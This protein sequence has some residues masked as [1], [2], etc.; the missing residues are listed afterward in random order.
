MWSVYLILPL[1]LKEV[2]SSSKIPPFYY[3]FVYYLFPSHYIPPVFHHGTQCNLH[4]VHWKSPIQILRLLQQGGGHM[5]PQTEHLCCDKER[6]DFNFYRE[7]KNKKMGRTGF[8]WRKTFCI[9]LKS[10]LLTMNNKPDIHMLQLPHTC[11]WPLLLERQWLGG[12]FPHPDAKELP[13]QH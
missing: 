5:C 1:I 12:L 6:R 8:F 13:Q 4:I 2:V 3:L 9:P 11:S 7:I 10:A